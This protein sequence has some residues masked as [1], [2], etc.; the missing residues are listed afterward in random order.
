MERNVKLQN[1]FNADFIKSKDNEEVDEFTF[2]MWKSELQ[3]ELKSF[4]RSM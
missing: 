2:S 3:R 1:E 4:W